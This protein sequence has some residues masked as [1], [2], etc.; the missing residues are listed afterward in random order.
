MRVVQRILRAFERLADASNGSSFPRIEELQI[1]VGRCS[2]NELT[3][4][5]SL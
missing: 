5:N 4:V 1:I 2:M 3:A